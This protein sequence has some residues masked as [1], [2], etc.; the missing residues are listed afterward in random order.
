MIK[1][2]S[3]FSSFANSKKIWNDLIRSS[4]TAGTQLPYQRR[5]QKVGP[6]RPCNAAAK[7]LTLSLIFWLGTLISSQAERPNVIIVIT[8]DQG[9][10]DFG[11]TGNKIIETPN[12]DAMAKRSVLWDNFYVSPVC[13]PTRA[14]LM[15]GRYNHR[16]YCVD[17]WLGRSMMAT[18]EVTIAEVLQEAGYATGIFG[19]WHL[20]DNYPM[21]TIDQGF[22]ESI[23]HRGGGLAQPADPIEND[24]RYTNPI[25]IHNGEEVA[26]KGYCTDVYFDH[27]QDWIRE[28]QKEDR[29]FFAYI[30]LNAPHGPYHDVPENLRKHYLK[31]DLASLIRNK[32]RDMEAEIDKLSRIAAMIT[33]ID[34]NVGRLFETLADTGL[35]QNTLVFVMTDN[36]PNTMR[37]VGD[38]RGM[39]TNV[40]EG[41]IRTPLWSHWPAGLKGGQTVED[42]VAAHIDLFPTIAEICDAKLPAGLQI[43]GRSILSQLKNP[44]QRMAPRPLFMQIH[45]GTQPQLYHN[46]MVRDSMW[47]LVHPSGFGTQTF[48]GKLNFQLYNVDEDPGETN[49]LKESFPHK[50]NYLKTLYEDWF[51]DVM[52]NVITNPGPPD[53]II[54]AAHENPSVL[55]WQDRV[56]EHWSPGSNGHWELDFAHTGSFDIQ[57]DMPREHAPMKDSSLKLT[58]GQTTYHKSIKAG[59]T[60]AQFTAIN[61]QPGPKDLRAELVTADGSTKG[62]YQVRVIAQ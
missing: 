47:K 5:A 44:A 7:W 18:E 16:T 50:F 28:M 40:T 53:I 12:I 20:G 57:V 29:P 30:P 46:F 22:E 3:N 61:V 25:L 26:T 49:D 8:D 21:R 19:K 54:D 39:K 23:V 31:K 36:G 4:G 43:D 14:S 17:T 6:L 33:N 62:A 24:R 15:T 1:R 45:R 59:T 48:K 11:A 35:Y 52:S 13:S 32:P 41:G 27:A 34:Q 55:T 56:A 42:T 60:S 58:I 2:S 37:Y 9:Y 38:M 10:G 51:K